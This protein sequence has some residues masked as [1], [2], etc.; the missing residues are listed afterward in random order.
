ME[1]S[2]ALT[3]SA[4]TKVSN[5]DYNCD[6]IVLVPRHL[7]FIAATVVVGSNPIKDKICANSS[8]E[9]KVVAV[10]EKMRHTGPRKLANGAAKLEGDDG[11]VYY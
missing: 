6:Q 5:A 2:D 7:H 3:P 11:L 8:K 10:F 4:L 9:A 1:K